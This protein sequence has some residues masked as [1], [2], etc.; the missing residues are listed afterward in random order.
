MHLALGS[1]ARIG[2]ERFL[3]LLNSG[4]ELLFKDMTRRLIHH[5]HSVRM[6]N[7]R[8]ARSVRRHV[9]GTSFLCVWC[10]KLGAKFLVQ[11]SG[12]S[13]WAENLGRM[14]WA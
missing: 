9:S 14:P 1:A 6:K 13:S 8:L 10:A 7:Q 5:L 12:T 4:V 2:K 3:V 11:D